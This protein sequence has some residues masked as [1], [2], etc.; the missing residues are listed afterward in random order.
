MALRDWKSVVAK[1]FPDP[2]PVTKEIVDANKGDIRLR[3]SVRM[4][5]GRVWDDDEYEARRDKVLNTPLR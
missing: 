1:E 2:G 4:A 5:T 3:G